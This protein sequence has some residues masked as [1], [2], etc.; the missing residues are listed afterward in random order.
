MTPNYRFHPHVLALFLAGASSIAAAQSSGTLTQMF[1]AQATT[2]L[3]GGTTQFFQPV[4]QNFG[5]ALPVNSMVVGETSGSLGA[6][7]VPEPPGSESLVPEPVVTPVPVPPSP[8]QVDLSPKEEVITQSLPVKVDDTST[9]AQILQL[10]EFEKRNQIG[11]A[12]LLAVELVNK[13]PNDEFAYDAAIRSSL[14]LGNEQEIE[15]YYR[16]AIKQSNLP[17]KYYVQLA[18]YYQRTGK[19]DQLQKLIGEYARTS[20]SAPDYRIT[21]ARL[22]S[23]AGDPDALTALFDKQGFTNEDIFPLLQVQIKAYA[24]AGQDDKATSII[25]SALQRDFGMGQQRLLLQELIRL[26]NPDPEQLVTLI[27][28]SLANETDYKEAREVADSVIAHAREKRYFTRLN[29]YLTSQGS[30]R[31]LSDMERWLQALMAETA[32]EQ[33]EALDILTA[34]EAGNTPVI[35]F[36]RAKALTRAGRAQEAIPSLATLLAEQP[37]NLEIRLLLA[38][39]LFRLKHTTNTLQLMA[40]LQFADLSVEDQARYAV[41]TVGSHIINRD[42]NRLLESWEDLAPRAAFEVLQAMGDTVVGTSSDADFRGRVAEA[43]LGR[44]DARPDTWPLFL[45]LARISATGTEPIAELNYYR[46]YLEHDR[47]NVQMLRFAAELAL[48]HASVPITLGPAQSGA[49]GI[50]LRASQADATAAAIQFYRRLIELQPRLPEN[51]S[52]LMRAYQIRGEVETA[53]KVALEYADRSSSSPEA[54]GASARMLEDNGFLEDSLAL[55]RAA[56]KED[57]EQYGIWMEYAVTLKA[58]GKL[59]PAN[60]ILKKILE[61]GFN[62]IPFNQPE[63]FSNLLSIAQDSGTTPALAAYLDEVRQKPLPGKAEFYVSSAKLLMQIGEPARARE[64]LEEFVQA[65]TDNRLLPDGLLLLGQLQYL[66]GEMDKATETFTRVQDD[67]S[68]TPAA[69]TAGFNIAEIERQQGQVQKAIAT[70]VRLAEA[71]PGSDKAQRAIYV[72]AL[73]AYN[74]LKNAD[75][76]VQL[77]DGYLQSGTQDFAMLRHA[78]RAAQNMRAGKPPLDNNPAPEG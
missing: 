6:V 78:Q 40:S 13:N 69:I 1:D 34:E 35:A 55:Y 64:F 5:T 32:G 9:A 49:K 21:L 39:Q 24:D 20:N 76:A 16:A 72:A 27:Q 26:K 11:E 65:E 48:Q 66:D 4:Q 56:L 45:L 25:L 7:T 50:N 10:A 28:S 23:V 77:M 17:G 71:S 47:D 70:W 31:R 59:E 42:V 74:D 37:D 14:V 38:D 29:D 67:H 53:K 57:P 15:K 22:F 33:K 60:V 58:A 12:F 41:L 8:E 44:I 68:T 19:M 63:I 52:A 43:A 62:D 46:D 30:T 2:S 51:Y 61:E 54:L 75:L 18:H 36:E 3:G 73:S